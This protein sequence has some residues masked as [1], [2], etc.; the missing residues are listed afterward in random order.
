MCIVE[1]HSWRSKS[2]SPRRT[3]CQYIPIVQ[4]RLGT[5]PH[6]IPNTHLSPSPL[7]RCPRGIWNTLS[8]LPLL[9]TCRPHTASTPGSAKGDSKRRS[10]PY[11]C[12]QYMQI[13]PFP[14]DTCLQDIPGSWV[15]RFLLGICPQGKPHMFGQQL[16]RSRSTFLQCMCSLC[17]T[18]CRFPSDTRLQHSRGTLFSPGQA[19]PCRQVRR[20]TMRR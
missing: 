12:F 15:F 7:R 5:F 11:T 9:Q 1:A 2:A 19:G 4:S 8:C 3:C 16:G 10:P 20:G 13:Y 6:C 17:T 14:V 18:A